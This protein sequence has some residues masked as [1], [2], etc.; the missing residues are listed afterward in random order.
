MNDLTP[1]ITIGFL[2]LTG[3]GVGWYI[4][5]GRFNNRQTKFR[6]AIE[7]LEIKVTNINKELDQDPLRAAINQGQRYVVNQL[8]TL[9]AQIKEGL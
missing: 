1:I 4:A 7:E 5:A 2:W 3:I 9:L 8:E 6:I